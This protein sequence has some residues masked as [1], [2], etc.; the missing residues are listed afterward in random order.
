MELIENLGHYIHGQL[1]IVD[2]MTDKCDSFTL[3]E[4]HGYITNIDEY[5]DCIKK[6][7]DNNYQT[8]IDNGGISCLLTKEDFRDVETF[9]TDC[10]ISLDFHIGNDKNIYRCGYE[11]DKTRTGIRP[12]TYYIEM[13][14]SINAKDINSLYQLF[15]A[16]F[17]HELTHAYE[18]YNRRKNKSLNIIDSCNKSGYFDATNG[19]ANAST[20]NG[21]LINRMYYR[22]SN[23]EL[24]AI[25]GQLYTEIK[26]LN[27]SI[28]GTVTAMSIIKQTEAWKCYE[29]LYNNIQ[30]LNGE[31]AANNPN[32]Q[33]QIVSEF[34]IYNRKQVKNY[35]DFLSLFNT[36]WN[37]WSKKFMQ[38]ASKIVYD[39]YMEQQNHRMTDS[40]NENNKEKLIK[41]K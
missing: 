20:Y 33:K 38:Q 14:F 3:N 21:Q 13:V 27:L 5:I 16:T 7:F 12:G 30:A 39:I 40:Y 37:K 8:I 35:Q 17:A 1:A 29:A 31:V 34:N 11:P 9:F 28:Y 23:T 10:K 4:S 26:G 6:W 18:D 15:M 19:M 36:R 32:T 41:I 25:I 24:K 2:C 22:M